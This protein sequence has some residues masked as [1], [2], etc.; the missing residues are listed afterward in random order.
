MKTSLIK[1]AFL[2]VAFAVPS[3][4]FA[5]SY[6]GVASGAT[7]V[8]AHSDSI[9]HSGRAQK[10]KAKVEQNGAER[11]SETRSAP[12]D[13]AYTHWDANMNAG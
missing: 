2:A 7:L 6:D 3:A 13:D 11:K 12:F 5:S 10:A 9:D 1:A 4:A 8:S